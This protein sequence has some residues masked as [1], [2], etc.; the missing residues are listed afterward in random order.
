M[1]SV[2]YSATWTCEP[3]TARPSVPTLGNFT[4]WL[5]SAR[6][7]GTLTTSSLVDVEWNLYAFPFRKGALEKAVK[8]RP[9][10][11]DRSAAA[12]ITLSSCVPACE[13]QIQPPSTRVAGR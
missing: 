8:G 13:T 6:K 10:Y 11:V 9:C 4:R 1:L 7:P 12:S 3:H 5:Q 2:K